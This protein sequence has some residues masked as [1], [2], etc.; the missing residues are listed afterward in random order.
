MRPPFSMAKSVAWQRS[1][2]SRGSGT[3]A[4]AMHGTSLLEPATG[5]VCQSSASQADA[6]TAVPVVV[7]TPIRMKHGWHE[8]T[9]TYPA[10]V[11]GCSVPWQ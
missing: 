6:H 7:A 2:F 5:G 8:S 9:A 1:V 10:A 3:C 11:T 4:V